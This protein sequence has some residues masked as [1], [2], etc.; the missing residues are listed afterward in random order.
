[1]RDNAGVMYRCMDVQ[2]ISGGEVIGGDR[3]MVARRDNVVTNEKTRWIS[4]GL[5]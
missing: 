4:T 3:R 2:E 5:N 1:M